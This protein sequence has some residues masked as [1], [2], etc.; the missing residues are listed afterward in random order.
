MD[1]VG[2]IGD[3]QAG[4]RHDYSTIDHIFT[5]HAIIYMYIKTVRKYMSLLLTKERHLISLIGCHYGTRWLLLG[6]MIKYFKLFTT[7]ITMQNLV[8]NQMEKCLVNFHVMLGLDT[9]VVL[10]LFKLFWTVHQSPLWWIENYGRGCEFILKRGHGTFLE[11]ICVAI[12]WWWY[13]CVGRNSWWITKSFKCSVRL[14]WNVVANGQYWE[15]EGS[16][17]FKSK[18]SKFPSFFVWS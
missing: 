9:T 12:S 18:S 14:L 2:V 4:F 17:F 13:D 10:Y 7:C 15:D 1:A 16:Y 11:I 8:W 6:L 5:L 3:Q